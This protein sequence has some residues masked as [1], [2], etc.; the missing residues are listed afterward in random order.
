MSLEIDQLVSEFVAKIV[1][2]AEVAAIDRAKAAVSI[3]FGGAYKDLVSTVRNGSAAAVGQE[4]K[5]GRPRQYCPVPGCSGVAAP[6]FGMVCS[7]HKNVAK[8]KIAK[9][10][11]ERKLQ[12]KSGAGKQSLQ[13]RFRS[14][15]GSTD[16]W[17]L[18]ATPAVKK[19]RNPRAKVLCPVPGCRGVAAPIFGM[20]CSAHRDM[21]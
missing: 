13:L 9:Y 10:R 18:D 2:A 5:S 14:M 1:T 12:L 20:V 17:A 16:G 19:P 4:S 7:E 15:E 21:A 6:I 3:A 8:S 11:K